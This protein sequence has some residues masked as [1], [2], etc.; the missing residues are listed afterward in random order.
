MNI[1]NTLRLAKTEQ[2][3]MIH[4]L[5]QSGGQGGV[6]DARCHDRADYDDATSILV[7]HQSC[8]AQAAYLV[9]PYNISA[10]GLAFLHGGYLHPGGDCLMLLRDI[11]RKAHQVRAKVVRCTHL[12]GRT[13]DV[14]VR[15]ER[16]I[17]VTQFAAAWPSTDD[18]QLVSRPLPRLG[19]RVLHISHAGADQ[20]LL[21][22]HL[23]ELGLEMHPGRNPNHLLRQ[24][25]RLS[26]DLLLVTERLPDTTLRTF[27][28][29]LRQRAWF[30]PVVVLES[31]DEPVD[32]DVTDT[33]GN[34]TVLHKPWTLEDLGEVIRQLLPAEPDGGPLVS[35]LWPERH[36]R[37]LILKFLAQL[38]ASL[39]QM[40]RLIA[41]QRD[42]QVVRQVCQEL[43]RTAATYGYPTI[44]Q[45]AMRLG[46]CIDCDE[47][48]PMQRQAFKEL[49]RLGHTACMLMRHWKR[50]TGASDLQKQS[51][52]GQVAATAA[53]SSARAAWTS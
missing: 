35:A 25:H 36:V 5:R 26:P 37:P 49:S 3:Q 50:T 42:P 46:R 8:Q 17:D 41:Q 31:G 19:G 28:S 48:T 21:G 32:A 24:I 53:G 13:H 52:A 39:R 22:V 33:I 9:R 4:E 11:N 30:G 2:D 20:E 43:Q 10:Q 44:E 12:R 47:P 29:D 34:T 23:R 38:D 14:G 7:V 18:Q 1:I 45:A 27:C 15:L 40:T 16:S 6:I 51:V